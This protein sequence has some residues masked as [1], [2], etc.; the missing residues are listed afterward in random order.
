MP[1]PWPISIIFSGPQIQPLA[2]TY[3]RFGNDTARDMARR[4]ANY[5]IYH[6]DYFLPDGE[7]NCHKGDDWF[8]ATIGH[9][10]SRL[11]TIAGAIHVG[12]IEHDHDLITTMKTCYD[13][14]VTNHCCDSGWSP[15]FLG[16]YG[17]ANEGCETCAVMDQ[18]KCCLALCDAGYHQYYQQ[19][20]RIAR[21]QLLENQLL[22]THLFQQ[23]VDKPDTDLSGYHDVADMVRG[24]FAGW[25]GVN[26]FQGTCA[27]N[28]NLMNC[29]GPAGIRAMYDIWNAIY[30]VDGSDIGVN[31][32]MDRQ[33]D[34][35]TITNRQPVDGIIDITVRTPCRLSLARRTWL[36]PADVTIDING[37]PH[38]P[39]IRNG[40][41]VL[42]NLKPGDRVC[43]HYP[44]S[45]TIETTH[46][47]GRGL[48]LHLARRHGG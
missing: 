13:W 38:R 45:D 6:T 23:S 10:H 25:A 7:W 18:I 21:N 19:A 34:E 20:E 24:G 15:E 35:L 42:D 17:D 22:D 30:T 39:A 43:I 41:I 5:I 12:L 9:T 2:E 14:F 27:N 8:A 32:F 4:I 29:C 33:G 36:N 11:A 16:R 3:R 31:I 46:V 1:G 47:N 40:T 28:D 48:P 37:A 26:D 44:I